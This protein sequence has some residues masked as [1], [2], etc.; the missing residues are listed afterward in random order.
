MNKDELVRLCNIDPDDEELALTAVTYQDAAE[1][2]LARIGVKTDYE[3]AEYKTLV[4][5][6]VK[7]YLD[8]TED[9]GLVSTYFISVAVALRNK[10]KVV[11]DNA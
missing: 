8:G 7:S 9:V 3:D 1:D 5:K 2:S 4:A 6:M 10:Q 11:S